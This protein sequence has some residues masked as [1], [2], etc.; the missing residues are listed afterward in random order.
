MG[1]QPLVSRTA[2][3][4]IGLER[5]VLTGKAARFPGRSDDWWAITWL[6]CRYC[7][8]KLGRAQR[9][10]LQLMPQFQTQIPDP[11]TDHLPGFLP[12]G[13]VTTPAVSGLL[14]VF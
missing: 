12:C 8:S 3:R 7:W 14:L 1:E 4:P 13:R 2:Q 5:K 11:L 6:R 10:W 9:G